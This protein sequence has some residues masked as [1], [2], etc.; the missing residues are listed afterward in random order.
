MSVFFG[1]GQV[2]YIMGNRFELGVIVSSPCCRIVYEG[3]A[4]PYVFFLA[5]NLHQ[6]D[7]CECLTQSCN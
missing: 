5:I 1:R 7:T 3:I 2:G 6:A 4:W